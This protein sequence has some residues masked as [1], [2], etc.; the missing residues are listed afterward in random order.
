MLYWGSIFT[1]PGKAAPPN[2]ISLGSV[3]SLNQQML[4]ISMAPLDLQELRYNSLP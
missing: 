3:A 1:P 2:Q 4:E